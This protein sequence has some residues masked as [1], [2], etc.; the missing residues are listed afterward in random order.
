MNDLVF[1]KF[2]PLNTRLLLAFP[3]FDGANSSVFR[4]YKWKDL[5]ASREGSRVFEGSAELHQTY[6]GTL[7]VRERASY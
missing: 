1:E 5:V 6:R 7:G 4:G 3:E 2:S